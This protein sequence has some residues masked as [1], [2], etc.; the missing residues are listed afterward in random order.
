[1]LLT[2][3]AHHDHMMNHSLLVCVSYVYLIC[4]HAISCLMF[5]VFQFDVFQFD[6]CCVLYVCIR[7]SRKP[8]NA[9]LTSVNTNNYTNYITQTTTPQSQSQQHQHQYPQP[10]PQP[11]PTPHPAPQP[12]HQSA[13]QSF[14]SSLTALLKRDKK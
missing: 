9:T 10:Q 2:F 13:V 6:A 1:M 14:A 11:T 5:D 3:S 12:V 8:S 4:I 7:S